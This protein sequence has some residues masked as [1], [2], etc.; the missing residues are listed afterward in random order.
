[1]HTGRESE[2]VFYEAECSWLQAAGRAGRFG[3][4]L[5]EATV[6]RDRLSITAE[7]WMQEMHTQNRLK[8]EDAS[9]DVIFVFLAQLAQTGSIRLAHPFSH[10]ISSHMLIPPTHCVP[11]LGQ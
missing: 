8:Q 5:Q 9:K 3:E 10:F 2:H 11:P 6:R 4:E 1:M 7:K